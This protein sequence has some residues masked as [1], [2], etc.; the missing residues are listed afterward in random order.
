MHI[1]ILWVKKITSA[2][3]TCGM[4]PLKLSKYSS[5][6]TP[7]TSTSWVLP[8]RAALTL[9]ASSLNTLMLS[10]SLLCFTWAGTSSCSRWK[11]CVFWRSS[12]EQAQLLVRENTVCCVFIA[13]VERGHLSHTVGKKKSHIVADLS[14]QWESLLMIV[15]RF[16]TEAWDEVTAE[17]HIWHVN[18]KIVR[19]NV[20]RTSK[21]S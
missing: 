16:A 19:P 9:E 1:F 4:T 12:T 21:S 7:S 6:L 15:F 13:G 18:M 10:S 3:G 17:A 14:D 5:L 8:I 20:Q 11:A 2:W